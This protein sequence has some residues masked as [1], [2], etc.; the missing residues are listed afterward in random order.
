MRPSA[1]TAFWS[2]DKV[3]GRFYFV[4]YSRSARAVTFDYTPRLGSFL[5]RGLPPATPSPRFHSPSVSS[6]SPLM[7]VVSSPDTRRQ[8]QKHSLFPPIGF[9]FIFVC[10][11]P[12][13]GPRRCSA[14]SI[15]PR[16][17][18]QVS[19]DTFK[20]IELPLMTKVQ[21]LVLFEVEHHEE[22]VLWITSFGGCEGDVS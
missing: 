18:A 2:S 22:A 16:V 14:V 9:N 11:V 13:W 17:A 12:T 19:T 1:V 6:T 4:I 15:G 7:D 21:C 5:E 20:I 10:E 3:L 8:M